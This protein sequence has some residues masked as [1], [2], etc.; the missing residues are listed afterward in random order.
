MKSILAVAVL[1]GLSLVVGQARDK[2]NK[3]TGNVEQALMRIER[4]MDDAVV[5]PLNSLLPK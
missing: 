1:T 3:Q 4:E 2:S 5:A